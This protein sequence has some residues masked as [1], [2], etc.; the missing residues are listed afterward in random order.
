MLGWKGFFYVE[1]NA[2]N[3]TIKGSIENFSA[4]IKSALILLAYTAVFLLISI[5]VFN[6]K[7]ILS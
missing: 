1:T 5:R 2:D 7:D 6:K 4:V 3:V